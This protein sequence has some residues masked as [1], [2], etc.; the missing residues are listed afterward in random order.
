MR[1]VEADQEWSL[2]CPHEC[3]GLEDTWGEEFEKLYEQYEREGRARKKVP[4][5]KLWFAVLESQTETG[6]PY[7]LYKD[8]CNRKSNQQVLS[9]QVTCIDESY[10]IVLV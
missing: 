1:R 10:L 4:A 6:T 5:Q 7:M 3:P 8:S 2:M 9:Q